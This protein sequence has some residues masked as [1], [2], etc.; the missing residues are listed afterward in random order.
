MEGYL[1]LAFKKPM[2][3]KALVQGWSGSEGA[4]VRVQGS[5]R[6][7]ENKAVTLT[8]SLLVLPPH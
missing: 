7:E 2:V 5:Q 1:V 8:L 3:L 4:T 6:K